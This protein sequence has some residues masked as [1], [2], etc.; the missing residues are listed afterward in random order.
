L[1]S[2]EL[3]VHCE[4]VTQADLT[5]AAGA[6]PCSDVHCLSQWHTQQLDEMPRNSNMEESAQRDSASCPLTPLVDTSKTMAREQIVD[7]LAVTINRKCYGG[8]VI[9]SSHELSSV[10]RIFN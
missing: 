6:K 7:P 1:E 3:D 5:R 8:G 10:M 4:P 9:G 2:G